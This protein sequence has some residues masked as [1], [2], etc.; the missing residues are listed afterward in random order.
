MDEREQGFTQDQIDRMY[1]RA[2][3][4]R[5]FREEAGLSE[6]ELAEKLDRTEGWVQDFEA[7]KIKDPLEPEFYKRLKSLNVDD[8]RIKLF[9]DVTGANVDTLIEVL[10]PREV[11]LME[12]G[13]KIPLYASDE[14]PNDEFQGLKQLMRWSH[15]EFR[16]GRRM[17]EML[18]WID[19]FGIQAN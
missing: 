15:Y 7:G 19:E 2:P 6:K 17:E 1:G 11:L 10:P 13:T 3:I 18:E 14:M 9:M 8:F 4:L 5:N 12:D 16:Y